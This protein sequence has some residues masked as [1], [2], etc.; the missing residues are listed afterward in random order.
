M[1]GTIAKPIFRLQP[2]AGEVYAGASAGGYAGAGA[3]AVMHYA[4]IDSEFAG[5]DALRMTYMRHTT[6]LGPTARSV[7]LCRS[8]LPH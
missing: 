8:R 5:L 1:R 3:I 4:T 6:R 7:A 2:R